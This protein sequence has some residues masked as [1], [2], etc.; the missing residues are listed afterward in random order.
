MS[1]PKDRAEIEAE[2]D[3]ELEQT[4]PA[5]DPPKVTRFP[6]GKEFTSAADVEGEP[7]ADEAPKPT[8]PEASDLK[9]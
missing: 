9:W 2:L 1:D 3:R 5:S 7:P 4:F 6:P 8:V